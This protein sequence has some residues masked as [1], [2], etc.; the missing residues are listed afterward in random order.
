MLYRE[1]IAVCSQIRTKHTNTLCGQN[2]ELYIKTQSVP[3][4][5]HTPS[6]LKHRQRDLDVGLSQQLQTVTP[7]RIIGKSDTSATKPSEASRGLWLAWR[8]TLTALR[9]TWR[10]VLFSGKYAP[11]FRKNFLP[12]FWG[13]TLDEGTVKHNS[14]KLGVKVVH[15]LNFNTKVHRPLHLLR[16]QC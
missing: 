16:T 10:G 1:I 8:M 6:H 9:V 12:P 11:T 3:R 7:W 14:V 15:S 2:V 5:K 4:S 13:Y